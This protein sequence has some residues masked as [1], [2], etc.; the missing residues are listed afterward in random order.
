VPPRAHAGV[1]READAG[2]AVDVAEDLRNI[3]VVVIIIIVVINI[4]IR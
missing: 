4:I 3:I 2:G 1:D